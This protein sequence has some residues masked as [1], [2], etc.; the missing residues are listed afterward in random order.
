VA[1]EKGADCVFE[2][3]AD[4]SHDPGYIPDFIAAIEEHDVVIGSRYVPGGGTENW[5]PL[6]KFISRGG[7]IYARVFTGLKVKDSTSGFRCYRKKVLESIDFSRISASGY[8][9]QVEMAY[10]CTI[11]GFDVYELPIVFVDRAEG[12]SKMSKSIVFEAMGLV[13]GLKKKYRDLNRNTGP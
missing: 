12:T 8:A 9:F 11:M 10:V 4:F 2:M 3:D 7:C 13:A 5:G 1:L 6:R